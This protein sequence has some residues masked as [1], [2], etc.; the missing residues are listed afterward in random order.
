MGLYFARVDLKNW[1]NFKNVD[2]AF[3]QRLY[4]VGPNATG[5]SNFL[6]VFRFLRDLVTDGGGLSPAVRQR[7][8]MA[9]L[10][11]LYART[12]SEVRHCAE[13]WQ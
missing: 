13:V 4:L 11:S 12:D 7:Q 8:G 6:D 9:G 5:K 10:R 2:L 3:Q 1:R